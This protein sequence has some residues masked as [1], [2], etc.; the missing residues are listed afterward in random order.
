MCE[1]YSDYLVAKIAQ[2]QGVS[3]AMADVS[4]EKEIILYRTSKN[5]TTR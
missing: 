1:K 2:P 3:V 4:Q 5:V